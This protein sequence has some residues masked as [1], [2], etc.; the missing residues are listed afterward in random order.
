MNIDKI[1]RQIKA[2]IDSIGI[3]LKSQKVLTEAGSG[4]YIV[5]P[6]IAAVAGAKHVI[7]CTRDSH[8][9]TVNDIKAHT[10]MLA[11]KFHVSDKIEV[12]TET[13][14]K[15]A[16]DIDI[17]TNLGFVRPINNQIIES[18][19]KHAVISLMW[20]PWEFRDSDID[21]KASI[22]NNIPII[23]TNENHPHLMTFKSVGL[24]ALKLLLEQ[25]CEILGTSILVIGSAPFGINCSD[26][27]VQLGA[28]V[29]LFD[30]TSNLPLSIDDTTLNQID[31]VVIVEHRSYQEILG[32][33]TPN[34]CEYLSTSQ[35]PVVHI[36]GVI[37]YSFFKYLNI[38]KYPVSEVA[39]GYMTVTTSYLGFKPVI[40]LH[41]V[42]LHVAS[43]VSRQRKNGCDIKSSLLNAINSG[44]GQNLSL[45]DI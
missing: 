35:I 25:S 4:P 30:P 33:S 40:D 3:D 24:L 17:V 21:I 6:V 32:K 11:D 7:A 8:W 9:G 29:I 10:M 14:W 44:Y 41:A 16:K 27:L 18:L 23:A 13:P 5:T 26:V 38:L 31:A 19:P 42:G 12:T 22:E 15:K 37:D 45:K 36:C 43:L 1:A 20:E 39:A 28:K 34:I 2:T